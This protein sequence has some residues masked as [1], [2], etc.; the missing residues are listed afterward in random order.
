MTASDPTTTFLTRGE[1]AEMLRV[2]AIYL[3]KLKHERRGPRVRKFGNADRSPVRYVLADVLAW[4]ADP[5]GHER[6]VWGD[7]QAQAKQTKSKAR[8]RRR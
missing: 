8:S 3:T 4:A 1:A 6:E 2:P 7:K 5:A